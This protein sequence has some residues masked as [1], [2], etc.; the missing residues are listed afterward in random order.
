MADAGRG[1]GYWLSIFANLAVVAGIVFLGIEIHQNT[2]MI[3]AQMNQSRTDAA[4]SQQQGTYNS[5]FMPSILVKL[6]NG[7]E[8]TAEEM[9]RYESYFRSFNRNMDNQL[10]QY[11]R[12]FLGTNIPRSVR[13]AVQQVIGGNQASLDLWDRQKASY[14]DEYAAFVEEALA[15]IRA[16][17]P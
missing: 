4:M 11:R 10:W 13:D 7:E 16:Q 8:L 17:V 1:F 5:E 2:S 12:G 3:E 14:T 15:E 9:R 6:E